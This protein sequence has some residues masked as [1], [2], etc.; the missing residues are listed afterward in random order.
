MH[1]FAV[2]LAAFA[3]HGGLEVDVVVVWDGVWAPLMAE[4]RRGFLG[5]ARRSVVFYSLIRGSWYGLRKTAECLKI[6]VLLVYVGVAICSH[7]AA[8]MDQYKFP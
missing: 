8:I 3:A 1:E 2:L 7:Q 4:L 5:L 6:L